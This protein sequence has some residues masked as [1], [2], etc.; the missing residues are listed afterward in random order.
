MNWESILTA[1][2][3]AIKN[4]PQ[5]AEDIILFILNLFVRNPKTVSSAVTAFS[6]LNKLNE[7]K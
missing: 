2:A 1:L 4:D 3:A 7:V 6:N 5:A